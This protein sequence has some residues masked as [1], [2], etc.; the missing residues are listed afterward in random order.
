MRFWANIQIYL[1][2]W[3]FTNEYSNIFGCP[4]IYE[5]IYLYWGNGTN[6][7]LN[8]IWGPFYLNIWIFEY[9]CSSLSPSFI[10]SFNNEIRYSRVRHYVFALL[11]YPKVDAM[12]YQTNLDILY[13]WFWIFLNSR[14]NKIT[15]YFDCEHEV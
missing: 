14:F 6:T 7:I 12:A 4:K 10:E 11:T 1:D 15:M 3:E 9:L 5:W 8:N 13:I 2:F